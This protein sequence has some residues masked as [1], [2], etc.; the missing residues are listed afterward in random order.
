MHRGHRLWLPSGS[1]DGS[2][3]NSR[4][5]CTTRSTRPA[6]ASTA[7]SIPR[8]ARSTSTRTSSRTRRTACSRASIS[9]TS[10]RRTAHGHAPVDWEVIGNARRG[11]RRPTTVGRPSL[12]PDRAS[13]PTCPARVR[14]VRRPSEHAV[15][16]LGLLRAALD[17][18]LPDER[19]QI[20]EVTGQ[21]MDFYAELFDQPYP[22]SKYDQIFVPEY[23]SGAMENVGCVTYNEAYLFR[24]NA[25]G[26]PA[27]RPR[28]DVPARARAHVVRQP[29]DDALVGRPVAQRE[30][31]P[32]TSATS[33]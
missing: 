29:R 6:T 9:P 1:P 13:A 7:S 32:R 30:L 21:G 8:T 33:R 15:H 18:A 20:L 28:R 23:N 24:D 11:I 19:P 3:W 14:A 16:P 12:R 22:F 26:Q 4:S 2:R 10:R 17:G 27:A 25:D 31:S 5:S